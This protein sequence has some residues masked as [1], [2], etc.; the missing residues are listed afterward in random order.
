M[1]FLGI[2]IIAIFLYIQ[3]YK[4]LALLLFFFFITSGFN[5]VP[6]EI[7]K[8]AFIS[9][10]SD[11]AF[12]L[13]VGIVA[14]DGIFN[15]GY[16]SKD[17]F[18][19]YLILFASFLII[20]IL[21]SKF[22]LKLGWGDILRT[23]RYQ[24]FWIAYFLFRHINKKTL[25]TLLKCLFFVALFTAVLFLL[26][27]V[28]DKNILIEMETGYIRL[29]GYKISR[30][31]NQPDMLFFFTFMALYHNPLNIILKYLS[32]IILT[33]ALLGAFHRSLTGCFFISVIIGFAI[34]LPYLKR[35]YFVAITSF[36]LLFTVVFFGYKFIHSRTYLDIEAVVTGN[37][38]TVEFDMEDLGN[39]TFTF[40]ILHLLERNQYILEHPK[41]MFLGAGLI[42]EDSKMVEK[43]F[44]FKIGLVEELTGN[45]VQIETG[46]ISYSVLFLRLGYVGTFLYL[47]LIIYLMIFFY[48]KRDNRYAFFSF[49]Y[50]MLTFGDSFFS[51][52]LLHPVTYL[53]PLISY[54][55]IK[56]TESEI[57]TNKN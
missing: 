36:I 49:L 50:L 10:G 3:N 35:I 1:V 38:D 28:I 56:K 34:N 32:M 27:I 15:R 37:I 17:N 8:F 40:R 14:I 39:S 16:F 18:T 48:K 44:D 47:L 19:K 51:A 22:V 4:I 29:F 9:K 6:E 43:T 26:Q 12:L 54:H 24:F 23:C 7:T 13:L 46:D 5:L 55:I 52:N 11:Y 57:V 25:E 31:Y 53:L 30:F 21:Y 41:A 45:A 2:V 42:P 20:C 33:A